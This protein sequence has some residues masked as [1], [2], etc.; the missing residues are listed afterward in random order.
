MSQY[1]ET[2]AHFS[3][4]MANHEPAMRMNCK[5][6]AEYK[7]WKKK[8]RNKLYSLLCLDRMT[9]CEPDPQ[10]LSSEKMDGYTREKWTI[11]TEP[12][13]VMT[14]YRLVPDGIAEGE[15]RPAVIA[16]EAPAGP[17]PATMTSYSPG[18]IRS[19]LRSSSPLATTSSSLSGIPRK[20]SG[21]HRP[22]IPE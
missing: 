6:A 5:T 11:K 1:Y 3:A 2:L 10:L 17:D 19:A 22:D 20:S 21:P 13:V 14:F 18:T 12:D 7:I 16:A 4:M 8:A 15:K 9:P